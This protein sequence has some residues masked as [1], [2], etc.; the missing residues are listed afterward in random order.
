MQWSTKWGDQGS[1]TIICLYTD[2]HEAVE[3][4]HGDGEGDDGD[5]RHERVGAALQL[6]VEVVVASEH[7]AQNPKQDPGWGPM[8]QL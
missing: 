1:W 6:G 4:E 3:D 2:Q 8:T 7:D 5:E